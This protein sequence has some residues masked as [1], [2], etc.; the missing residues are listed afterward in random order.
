MERGK[1]AVELE[2]PSPST[3]VSTT[4][5]GRMFLVLAR[6]DESPGPQV[7]EVLGGEFR[8]YPDEAWNGPGDDP[9]QRF[10]RVNAQRVGPD[11]DLWLVDVGAPGIGNPT[12][13]GG[14]KLVRVDL[15]SNEVARTY[16]LDAALTTDSF[17]DDVRFN[18][19]RAYITD[20][21]DRA[22]VVVDLTSGRVRR[23]L[24]HH[25]STTAQR[26][27]T[28][29]GVELRDAE[30]EPVFIHNDQLEVSPDGRWLYFQPCCGP[31]YR[32]ETRLLDDPEVEAGQLESA[33]EYFAATGSTG[34]TAIAASG[35]IYVSNTDARR[36]SA[37][38]PDGRLT[39]V[40]D[41]PRLSWVD[42]MWV[43]G[44]KLWM[45]AAQLQLTSTF[46]GGRD[47]VQPP[48]QVLSI[49]LD[50]LPAANDH[51]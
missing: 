24:H 46:Q 4:P 5:D 12:L 23:L 42:A 22:L 36:I 3:G 48:L 16:P 14:P 40:I 37:I 10:V 39:T 29:D 15:T 33:V 32:V 2:P 18:G 44:G 49:E 38:A 43:G 31:L 8:P 25:Y 41:D 51:A 20:A 50:D 34:G 21:G 26:A 7:V 35:T 17:V 47:R 1:I 30:G 19:E 28:A 11:G 13:A 27:M 9:A 45:P 6:I